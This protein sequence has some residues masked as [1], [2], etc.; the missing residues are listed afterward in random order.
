L[1]VE[2]KEE[3]EYGD[4]LAEVRHHDLHNKHQLICIS[5]SF[6]NLP[7]YG[8]HPTN[9]QLKQETYLLKVVLP[10]ITA[11]YPCRFEGNACLLLG[12]SKSGWG[13]WSL[14]LRHPQ[15]FFRAAAW[16]APLTETTP[17]RYG[18]SI[19]FTNEEQFLDYELPGVIERRAVTLREREQLGVFGYDNFR[20]QAFA[21]H[22]LLERLD[23]PHGYS[24]SQQRKHRWD[25]GWVPE[26]IEFL[27]SDD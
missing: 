24:N 20:D 14:A 19:V 7:W 10:A 22:A 3:H 11:N 18:M 21:M 27:V 12:F 1:P 4:G 6:S 26:A 23:I 15:L 25:S 16:D 13:A 9:P 2:P 5:P 17:A 8:D